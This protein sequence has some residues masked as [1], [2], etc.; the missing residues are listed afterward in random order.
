MFVLY[1]I[2]NCEFITFVSK[3]MD[4]LFILLLSLLLNSLCHCCGLL[5]C[6]SLSR[7]AEDFETIY[8][9]LWYCSIVCVTTGG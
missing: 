5:H 3:I 7:S 4:S 8:S 9:S 1:G 6:R 2:T